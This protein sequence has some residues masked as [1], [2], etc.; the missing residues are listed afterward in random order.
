MKIFLL[1]ISILLIY[2]AALLVSH[3][4]PGLG[5]DNYE[6]NSITSEN[7]RYLGKIPQAV[8]VGSS[9]TNFFDYE[10]LDAENVF[11][12]GYGGQGALTGLEVLNRSSTL[13]KLILV[14]VGDTLEWTA[15]EHCVKLASDDFE[16]GDVLSVFQHRFQPCAIALLFYNKV[17]PRELP[18]LDS[19][20]HLI[21]VR[22]HDLSMPLNQEKRVAFSNNCEKALVL[23]D[24][25]QAR[26]VKV[27]IFDPPV[28]ASVADS[29]FVSETKAFINKRLAD[30]HLTVLENPEGDWQTR[31]GTHLMP[32]SGK[33][34]SV[35]LRSQ[36]EVLLGHP[37]AGSK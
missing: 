25:L 19:R 30:A 13:P 3:A 18:D 32:E 37:G 21:G 6:T 7:F 24:S 29:R 4:E 15:D 8:I 5:R 1:T 36:I 16:L 17:F 2:Q 26:G 11:H 27:V 33:L 14:E 22:L 9:K 20:Q 23:I 28:E 12:F 31:D 34:Y 35:W 10:I